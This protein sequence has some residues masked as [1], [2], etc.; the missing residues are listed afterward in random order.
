[1]SLII[2]RKKGKEVVISE[3]EKILQVHRETAEVVEAERKRV[4]L[5]KQ[6]HQAANLIIKAWRQ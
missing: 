1:M 3:E 5:V 6:K 2:C 4:D